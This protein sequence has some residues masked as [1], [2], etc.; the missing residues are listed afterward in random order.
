ML[1]LL[2]LRRRKKGRKHR[3]H[4]FK[5]IKCDFFSQDYNNLTSTSWPPRKL[6][7]ARQTHHNGVCTSHI[8]QSVT[9]C[10]IPSFIY[11]RESVS[12]ISDCLVLKEHASLFEKIEVSG[13]QISQF[14]V[15]TAKHLHNFFKVYYLFSYITALIRDTWQIHFATRIRTNIHRQTTGKFSGNSQSTNSLATQP[16]CVL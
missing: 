13:M 5:K 2:S 9:K 7:F 12:S 1:L 8:H 6:M 11:I 10:E 14:S 16:N 15:Q 3:S 4:T